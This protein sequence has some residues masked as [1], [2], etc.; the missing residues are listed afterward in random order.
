MSFLDPDRLKALNF[1]R[2]DAIPVSISILPSAWIKHRDALDAIV[3]RHPFLFGRS[4]QQRDYD[5]VMN[6]TYTAGDHVDVWG[7]VWSNVHHGQESIVT[8]HPLPTR[9]DVRRLAMPTRDA[10]LP[11]GFMYLRLLDLRGFEEM[12]VDFAEEPPELQRLIDIVLAYNQRQ[13]T[14]ELAKSKEPGMYGFGDDLGM[15]HALPISPEKWRRYLKPCYAAMYGRWRAAGHTVYMH[16][17]GHIVPIIPD[18]LDCGVQILN[19]Q[20]RANGLEGLV[21]ACKGKVCVD[22]DLDRQMFPFCAPADID[23]HVVEAI[24][25]LGSP[26]GGLWLKAEV[27]DGVPLANVEA[28]C[29]TLE[30]H[31]HHFAR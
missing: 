1:D 2:P 13:L 29:V 18:L 17:D 30:H 27:D 5:T 21:R 20:I 6:P 12:M 22:L 23:R 15:Q 19:P 24:E 11:H 9:E 31:R 26:E 28:L 3:R 10:G 16:T 25:A 8:R 7:C 14:L 4:D